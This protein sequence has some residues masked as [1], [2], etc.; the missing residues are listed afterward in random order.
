MAGI[1]RNGHKC[2]IVIV[3]PLVRLEN[4]KETWKKIVKYIQS[5]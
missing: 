2:V 5:I 4:I 1:A 3:V